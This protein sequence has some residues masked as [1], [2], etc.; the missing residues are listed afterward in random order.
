M[1]TTTEESDSSWISLTVPM[2]MPANRTILPG[3]NPRIAVNE[4]CTSLV[5]VERFCLHRSNE[6]SM[7]NSRSADAMKI[8][9]RNAL[10]VLFILLIIY[11]SFVSVIFKQNVR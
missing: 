3:I 5:E 11:V 10:F 4:A 2:F 7:S 8:P 9:N 1:V 6:I